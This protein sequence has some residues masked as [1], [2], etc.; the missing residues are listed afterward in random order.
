MDPARALARVRPDGG[1]ALGREGIV[2]EAVQDGSPASVYV[3]AQPD[4]PLAGRVREISDRAEYT[5]RQSIT[6]NERSNLVFAVKVGI[7]NTDGL[8][9][10]GMPADVIF[11]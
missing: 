10:P 4:T 7:D 9:K 1:D 2:E 5:P 3:D 11:P 6:R 8:V